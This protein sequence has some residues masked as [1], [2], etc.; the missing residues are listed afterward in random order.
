MIARYIIVQTIL[1]WV[2]FNFVLP[3]NALHKI[4]MYPLAFVLSILTS[5][6]Y[7]YYQEKKYW[8]NVYENQYILSIHPRSR[9]EVVFSGDLEEINKNIHSVPTKRIGQKTKEI[10]TNLVEAEND[11]LL[12]PSQ[13]WQKLKIIALPFQEGQYINETWEEYWVRVTEVIKED[14]STRHKVLKDA[15]GGNWYKKIHQKQ[16]IL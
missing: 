14:R 12:G 6:F 1:Y 5:F 3:V 4:V 13:D 11:Y 7:Y 15:K 8:S 2:A 9:E 10:Y 16:I